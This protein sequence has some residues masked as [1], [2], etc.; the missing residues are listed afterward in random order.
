MH[1]RL[2]IANLAPAG[3]LFRRLVGCAGAFLSVLASG[4]GDHNVDLGGGGPPPPPG[5]RTPA[6]T[7]ARFQTMYESQ[8]TAELGKLL[9]ANFSFRFSTQSDPTLAQ[10]YGSTWD[11]ADELASAGHLFDGFTSPDPPYVTFGPATSISLAFV[12]MQILDDLLLPDS[13]RFYKYV[14]VPSANLTITVVNGAIETIYEISAPQ[15]FYL[16]RGDVALLDSG[17][18]A[19]STYWYIYRW[20]DRNPAPATSP[21]ATGP[22]RSLARFMP[23]EPSSWGRIKADYH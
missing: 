23:V 11:K 1:R 5:N 17:Q 21:Q 9:T 18:P 20:D 8:N 15:D 2:A 22:T 16:V 19:D 14:V 7:I 12:N 13:S 4:C 3:R 10:Q 6:L